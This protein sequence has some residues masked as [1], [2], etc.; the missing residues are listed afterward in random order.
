MRF[1][2][3]MK[4]KSFRNFYYFFVFKNFEMMKKLCKAA[5][6]ALRR[7]RAVPINT[8]KAVIAQVKV[9]KQVKRSQVQVLNIFDASFILVL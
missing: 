2:E 4:E 3:L 9:A 6:H 5:N 1:S 8:D 7:K